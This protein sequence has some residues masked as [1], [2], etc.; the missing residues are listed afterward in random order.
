VALPSSLQQWSGLLA[1]CVD[2]RAQRFIGGQYD[3]AERFLPA[4]STSALVTT[5]KDNVAKAAMLSAA[6]IRMRKSSSC[7]RE[8][9]AAVS[10][11]TILA[12]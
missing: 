4:A 3:F 2:W 9:Q 1:W 7:D 5:L 6:R 11:A 8:P 10:C 12:R